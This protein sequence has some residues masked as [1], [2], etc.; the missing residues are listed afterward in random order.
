MTTQA[1]LS[2]QARNIILATMSGA[3]DEMIAQV[4]KYASDSQQQTGDKC[5]GVISSC[6]RDK[7]VRVY[8]LMQDGDRGDVY[9][10]IGYTVHGFM[11]WFDCMSE[12]YDRV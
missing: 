4:M 9:L 2:T 6:V 5:I 12:L 7:P 3:S 1:K 10:D 11:A 8:A